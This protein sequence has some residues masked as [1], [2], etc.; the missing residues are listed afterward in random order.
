MTG[1]MRR[2]MRSPRRG[3]GDRRSQE[4]KISLLG[5]KVSKRSGGRSGGS[6]GFTDQD[7]DQV[8]SAQYPTGLKSVNRGIS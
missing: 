3:W 7:E 4:K 1:D 8:L 6:G 2:K 5:R